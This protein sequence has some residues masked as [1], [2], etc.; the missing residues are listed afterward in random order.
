MKNDHVRM[1][2]TQSLVH[3]VKFRQLSILKVLKW[4]TC[5]PRDVQALP[6]TRTS[7]IPERPR[8]VHWSRNDWLSW[9]LFASTCGTK[10]TTSIVCIVQFSLCI[11]EVGMGGLMQ[12]LPLSV[13]LP[14]HSWKLYSELLHSNKLTFSAGLSPGQV[15]DE[16]N[17]FIT[18]WTFQA[19]MYM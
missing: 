14:R 8:S 5:F 4:I 17:Y 3:I 1:L 15:R 2:I 9:G 11:L 12:W 6:N 18:A 13:W 7:P 10:F 19:T 16:N